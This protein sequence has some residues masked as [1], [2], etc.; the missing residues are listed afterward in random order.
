MQ[1][2]S[3]KDLH[4]KA[5]TETKTKVEAETESPVTLRSY[6]ETI[7]LSTDL[8]TKWNPPPSLSFGLILIEN[9]LTIYI[10]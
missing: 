5:G 8:V 2:V 7:A 3:P 6:N 9:L 10:S 4:P 1:S